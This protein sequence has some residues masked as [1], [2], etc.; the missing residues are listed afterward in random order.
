MSTGS[1][2]ISCREVDGFPIPMRGNE[3]VYWIFAAFAVWVSNPH[4]G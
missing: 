3:L 1:P 2:S 4:E